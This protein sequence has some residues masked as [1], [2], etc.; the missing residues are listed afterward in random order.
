MD[1][2]LPHGTCFSPTRNCVC[3]KAHSA[4]TMRSDLAVPWP[5][6]W[7]VEREVWET[8]NDGKRVGY[9]WSMNGLWECRELIKQ[10]RLQAIVD[11]SYCWMYLVVSA[12]QVIRLQVSTPST[13]HLWFHAPREKMK[14]N[15]RTSK[16]GFR[17]LKHGL[18]HCEMFFLHLFIWAMELPLAGFNLI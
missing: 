3:D 15:Y 9:S 17:K 14:H 11:K 16:L 12:L 10:S 8:I 4:E 6:G 5:W 13:K 7:S 1:S 2:R 18:A